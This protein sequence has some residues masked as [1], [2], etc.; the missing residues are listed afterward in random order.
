METWL[1]GGAWMEECRLA[2]PLMMSKEVSMAETILITELIN[3]LAKP[4][5]QYCP[6][7]VLRLC[8]RSRWWCQE[9]SW[10]CIGWRNLNE[11]LKKMKSW[12]CRRWTRSTWW[13]WWTRWTRWT[14]LTRFKSLLIHWCW[15]YKILLMRTV[16]V[17]RLAYEGRWVARTDWRWGWQWGTN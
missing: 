5:V 7:A 13:T 8:W 1:L 6:T 14:R 2:D 12:R 17:W 9:R 11:I 16:W 10:W 3:N 15:N 4:Y